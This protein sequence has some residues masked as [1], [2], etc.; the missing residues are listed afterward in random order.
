MSG[1]GRRTQRTTSSRATSPR[2][3]RRAHIDRLTPVL[4]DN[5]LPAAPRRR[6]SHGFGAAATLALQFDVDTPS[7]VAVLSLTSGLELDERSR[8]ACAT[9]RA[10]WPNGSARFLPLLCDR[11]ATD[12]GRRARRFV[13][14][15]YL[16][17]QTACRVRM[18]AEE[19]GMAAAGP[20]HRARSA[21]GFLL[22]A[23]GFEGFFERM[24]ELGDALLLDT[25]VLE[26]HAGVTPRAKTDTAATSS[27]T[28]T[29]PTPGCA[30]SPKLPPMP[31][32]PSSSAATRS[33]P[34]A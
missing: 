5:A 31:H 10:S 23:V 20:G 17:P 27:T 8:L 2:G 32:S 33:S 24:A 34:A 7:D 26:A 4:R 30:P 14:W 25:R 9:G 6:G 11:D 1:R 3:N 22:E 12:H 19:R 28:N 16:E 21:L 15:Q 13:D 29:S 18:F